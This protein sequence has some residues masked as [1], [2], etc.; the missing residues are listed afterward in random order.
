MNTL[1]VF[2]AMVVIT[3]A[4]SLLFM[5]SGCAGGPTSRSTGEFVDDAS[6]TAKVKAALVQDPVVSALDVGVDTYKGRVQ[7]NGFVDTPEQKARAEQVARTVA[8]VESIGNQLAVKT[9][10]QR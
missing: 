6:I 5:V 1:R 4:S 9:Q 10:A 7:L 2:L 8:G 3:L